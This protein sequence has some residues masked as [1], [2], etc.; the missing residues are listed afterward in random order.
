MSLPMLAL[1]T[2]LFVIPCVLLWMGH[3]LRRRPAAWRATFW[4]AVIGYVVGMTATLAA[5]HYP[6]V[7]WGDGGV[8]TALVFWGMLAGAIVGAAAG[9]MLAGRRE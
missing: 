5:M 7:P 4:G 3:R 8:R 6:P 9:R 1:L 2:G